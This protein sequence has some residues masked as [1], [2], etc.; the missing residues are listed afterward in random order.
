[1]SR[2]STPPLHTQGVS[3]IFQQSVKQLGQRESHGSIEGKKEWRQRDYES[4]DKNQLNNV[5]E[6]KLSSRNTNQFKTDRESVYHMS[7]SNS[8]PGSVV[9][10]RPCQRQKDRESNQV[11]EEKLVTSFIINHFAEDWTS[12][13]LTPETFDTNTS[14]YGP[15]Q[16]TPKFQSE[17]AERYADKFDNA[18][19]A[20]AKKNEEKVAQFVDQNNKEVNSDRTLYNDNILHEKKLP[21]NSHCSQSV[22]NEL[23]KV[24]KAKKRINGRMEV[25]SSVKEIHKSFD[26]KEKC[27]A[28]AGTRQHGFSV[29]KNK[30]V[31]LSV[32]EYENKENICIK[33]TQMEID[34][35]NDEHKSH[36]SDKHSS[37]IIIGD[38]SSFE[39]TLVKEDKTK[40]L[41]VNQINTS[42]IPPVQNDTKAICTLNKSRGKD[43]DRNG[44]YD[45][46]MTSRGYEYKSHSLHSNEPW[47]MRHPHKYKGN[48]SKCNWSFRHSTCTNNRKNQHEL[49]P[50]IP[51]RF[52][53]KHS[54]PREQKSYRSLCKSASEKGMKKLLISNDQVKLVDICD[55][56]VFSKKFG[57][58]S[59]GLT[60][61]VHHSKVKEPVQSSEIGTEEKIVVSSQDVEIKEKPPDACQPWIIPCSEDWLAEI[62][63]EKNG[64]VFK[65]DN[66]NNLNAMD[67]TNEYDTNRTS[68]Y[69]TIKDEF[70]LKNTVS[71][72]QPNTSGSKLV[73]GFEHREDKYL[74]A[75]EHE[76]FTI[77]NTED[78]EVN[79]FEEGLEFDK[80][81]Q[82]V[83]KMD[84]LNKD[85]DLDNVTYAEQ[86]KEM[87][88]NSMPYLPPPPPCSDYM[89]V[90]MKGIPNADEN[91]IADKLAE[92]SA[93]QDNILLES[94]GHNRNL[95]PAG[96]E[97][98]VENSYV[99]ACKDDETES[100]K[101][102]DKFDKLIGCTSEDVSELPSNEVVNNISIY[103][104]CSLDQSCL[105]MPDSPESQENTLDYGSD[106]ETCVDTTKS[107][108][109]Q[110]PMDCMTDD[111]SKNWLNFQYDS[112]YW[113]WY[114]YMCS[115]SIK[116]N[117]EWQSQAY[118]K[119]VNNISKRKVQQSG[120]RDKIECNHKEKKSTGNHSEPLTEVP[121][122]DLV[123]DRTTSW[124]NSQI[125]HNP[126]SQTSTHQS[127]V[128]EN[129]SQKHNTGESH[130]FEVKTPNNNYDKINAPM[131]ANDATRQHWHHLSSVD[132]DQN[133]TSTR[134]MDRGEGLYTCYCMDRSI[135]YVTWRMCYC[136]PPRLCGVYYRGDTNT[137]LGYWSY[138]SNTG[139]GEYLW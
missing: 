125:F 37:Q 32:T 112:A 27:S 135:Q 24:Q 47:K 44:H 43:K 77:E 111:D 138:E 76:R 137:D 95:T 57:Q 99:L 75:C 126:S 103:D 93:T 10:E 60:D 39:E 13:E 30:M 22:G 91:Y 3:R 65:Q 64:S 49:K 114:Y 92:K 117:M 105:E 35:F 45:L 4:K 51:P 58:L 40:A 62:T 110:W 54:H 100:T 79:K 81:K 36:D 116:N 15:L 123:T 21:L 90:P 85:N 42:N 26:S 88:K 87:V 78:F 122:S 118:N 19:S 67:T 129:G 50:T 17:L 86:T 128:Q 55:R 98:T 34:M 31:S 61:S 139:T 89:Y 69:Q 127:H 8:K 115:K 136:G 25:I 104:N 97:Y 71:F 41:P 108:Y 68:V 6:R 33:E 83:K 82:D 107:Q 5:K 46:N 134:D 14:E 124:V 74:I 113:S 101:R 120:R 59:L 132:T 106:Y 73:C 119:H 70:P 29:H 56:P 7:A 16:S 20:F 66:I 18:T 53:K 130:Y 23:N 94:E 38:T 109:S 131:D 52:S 12:D 28:V 9:S 1:M 63:E 72:K 102:G 96:D 84:K 80:N 2:R 48:E 133:V 11:T 121:S